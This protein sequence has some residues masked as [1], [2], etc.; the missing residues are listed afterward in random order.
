M[1]ADVATVQQNMLL[2]QNHPDFFV[3]STVW[4]TMA[5]AERRK[6]G[7]RAVVDTIVDQTKLLVEVSRS[8]TA[9]LA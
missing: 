4:S 2:E 9:V 6:E 3:N 7:L 5:P 8:I 1:W